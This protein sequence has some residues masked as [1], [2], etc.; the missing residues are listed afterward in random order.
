MYHKYGTVVELKNELDRQRDNSWDT[1]TPTG[2]LSFIPHDTGLTLG[3]SPQ[4]TPTGEM[5]TVEQIELPLNDWAKRQVCQKLEFPWV[6]YRKCEEHDKTQLLADNLNTWLREME[7]NLMVRTLD[8]Q[9][10][11]VLSDSYMFVDNVSVLLTALQT[12]K[13]LEGEGFW[14]KPILL[15]RSDLSDTSMYI[16]AGVDTPIALTPNEMVYPGILLQNSEVGASYMRVR[17]AL[18]NPLCKNIMAS[19]VAFEVKHLGSRKDA[20]IIHW[21][22]QTRYF[23]NEAVKSRVVDC[24][25]QG[26]LPTFFERW[27]G[28]IRDN[29]N[30]E[31]VCSRETAV[32]AL[33][34]E[35]GVCES[36]GK[37]I[38]EYYSDQKHNLYGLGNAVTR[39]AQDVSPDRAVELEIIGGQVATIHGP[40]FNKTVEKVIEEQKLEGKQ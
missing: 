30:F 16:K 35:F 32:E 33:K 17:P 36:E 7:R 10:R 6:Y 9:V 27:I 21:S 38:L 8:N 40:Q 4:D 18:L 31:L 5:V 14:N 23:E 37:H 1:I 29:I 39:Y 3:I 22:D 26:F 20:G 2:T 34:I 11:A 28:A 24:I 12:F 25:R 13:E 15:W 19:I